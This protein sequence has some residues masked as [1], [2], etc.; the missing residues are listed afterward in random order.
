MP[1]AP[2]PPM[3]RLEVE[4]PVNVPVPVTVPF[5]VSVLV[6]ILKLPLVIA[7]IPLKVIPWF[8]RTT[9]PARLMVRFVIEGVAVNNPL[10]KVN[11]VALAPKLMEEPA[12]VVIVPEVLEIFP[13]SVIVFAPIEKAPEVRVR[14]P[15]IVL[16]IEAP[17]VTPAELL[18]TTSVGPLV[19]GHS[20]EV[21]V[22]EAEPL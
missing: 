10:G 14:F 3:V 20:T 8:P 7:N 22:C 9:P 19:V 17:K 13:A 12:A 21:A 15:A 6:P 11:A 16:D 18:I 1:N 4:E 2:V 5:R